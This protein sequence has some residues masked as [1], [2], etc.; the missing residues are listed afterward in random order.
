M[1]YYNAPRQRKLEKLTFSGTVLK[2]KKMEKKKEK[3]KC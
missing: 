3:I 1:I 2:D